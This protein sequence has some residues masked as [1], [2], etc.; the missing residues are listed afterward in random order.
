[1]ARCKCSVCGKEFEKNPG[2]MYKRRKDGKAADQ[3]SYT[4]YRKEGGDNGKYGKPKSSQ[5]DSSL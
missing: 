2:H 1:M 3:C 4:C 5:P